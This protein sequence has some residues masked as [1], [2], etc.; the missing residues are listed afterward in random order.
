MGRNL[1]S[2][3]ETITI[4]RRTINAST[5]CVCTYV[6][7]ESVVIMQIAYPRRT[8]QCV[9]VLLEPLETHWLDARLYLLQVLWLYRYNL[10]YP[11]SLS[12]TWGIH[13][14]SHRTSLGCLSVPGAR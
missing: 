3:A 4:A 10:E 9:C 7:L 14:M 5:A 2:P 8:D 1:Q 6:I 12:S 13:S 11:A